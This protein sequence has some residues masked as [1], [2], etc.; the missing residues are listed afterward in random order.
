M[1]TLT[2]SRNTEN[3][4][5]RK[6]ISHCVILIVDDSESDRFTYR[7]YLESSDQFKCHISDCES[8]EEAIEH[9]KTNC[10][11]LILLDYLLPVASGLDFLQSITQQ[12]G[13]LPSVIMLTGQGNEEVA[14]EAMKQGV[15]DYLIKGQVTAQT[16][17][18]SVTN[19]LMAQALQ[20][21]IDRQGQ[22]RELFTNI[23]L[24]IS[25]LVELCQIL[26]VAV[27]GTREL[28]GCDRTLVYR[29]DHEMSGTIV[30]ES[31]SEEWPAM[32]DRHFENSGLQRDQALH[33]QEYLQGQNLVISDIESAQF[34]DSHRQILRELHV[35]AVLVIPIV[36]RDFSASNEP[37]L[38]GL[39]VAHHCRAVHEWQPD[40][41]SFLEELA[42]P[43][44][45]AIQQAEL[46]SD[47]KATLTHQQAIEDQ[48]NYRVVEI[49]Q[50]NLHLS[51]AT[52][53]LEKRNRELDEFSHIVSHDL[54]APLRGIANLAEWVVSD[55]E[56]KLPPRINSS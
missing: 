12:L 41:L 50:A 13:H 42:I 35:K 7:R 21:K 37:V 15:K 1:T 52:R 25:R 34:T 49:E 28:I 3:P 16:L 47:L 14:V 8:A 33:M 10:P 39:L 38:W 32:V 40:E 31:V 43:M 30:V 6:L 24:S 20:S 51:Q 45:I 2:E 19:V 55:L 44:A 36:F 9:C 18:R 46:L 23:S 29:L 54:Q 5:D 53:V 17:V 48:L 11:D 27:E 56:G 22:Q 26:K 4:E